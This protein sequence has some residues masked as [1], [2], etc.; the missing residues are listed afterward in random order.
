MLYESVKKQVSQ[1]WT[2]FNIYGMK[3]LVNGLK[4]HLQDIFNV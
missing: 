3:L 4:Q 1:I 2:P